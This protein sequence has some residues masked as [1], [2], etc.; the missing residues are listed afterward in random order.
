MPSRDDIL[1]GSWAVFDRAVRN[2][3]GAVIRPSVPNVWFGDLPAY[4]ASPLRVVTVGLNPSNEEFP[5]TN[6]FCRFPGAASLALRA[7]AESGEFD[8]YPCQLRELTTR[9]SNCMK[10]LFQELHDSLVLPTGPFVTLLDRLR[11][12]AG[13]DGQLQRVVIPPPDQGVSP[14]SLTTPRA[15]AR[16]HFLSG[17]LHPAAVP[18]NCLSVAADCL[19][20]S[21]CRCP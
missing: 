2:A 10:R 1:R 8:T 17:F 14:C 12:G 13:R 16:S 4:E 5:S 18:E 11:R 9:Q 19:I 21:S 6:P 20:C 3:P 7:P 15:R